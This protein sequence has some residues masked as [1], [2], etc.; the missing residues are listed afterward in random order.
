MPNLREL[1]RVGRRTLEGERADLLGGV[2]RR[3]A[4]VLQDGG[5]TEP[6]VLAASGPG[7]IAEG[8]ELLVAMDHV[9]PVAHL[10]PADEGQD[11]VRC[12][13]EGMEDQTEIVVPY[14]WE[15]TECAVAGPLHQE[16]GFAAAHL[17]LH[18]ERTFSEGPDLEA[19][20][21]QKPTVGGPTRLE[22][23]FGIVKQIDVSREPWRLEERVQRGG[24]GDVA[25]TRGD[26]GFRYET[27]DL[28]LDCCKSHCR[29]SAAFW[30]A[31]RSP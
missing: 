30:K 8:L 4:R 5:G 17:C 14:Q 7:E 12:K 2:A 13:V 15:E 28:A 11:F 31:F 24:S 29:A 26:A 1:R 18:E 21:L 20:I 9:H 27:A 3:L 22:G 6:G 10:E 23:L 16:G 25:L 19:R